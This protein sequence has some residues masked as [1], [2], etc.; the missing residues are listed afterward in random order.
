MG[1]LFLRK[2]YPEIIYCD[3]CTTNH[4][5]VIIDFA[6]PVAPSGQCR[7]CYILSSR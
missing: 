3:M 2:T 4:P 5:T 6:V 7:L 1:G